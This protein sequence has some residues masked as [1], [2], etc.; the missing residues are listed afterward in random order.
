MQP[1]PVS[2]LLLDCFVALPWHHPGPTCCLFILEMAFPHESPKVLWPE[3]LLFPLIFSKFMTP[4]FTHKRQSYFCNAQSSIRQNLNAPTVVAWWSLACQSA[5]E[6]ASVNIAGFPHG[7]G[8]TEM[9]R[10]GTQNRPITQRSGLTIGPVK[11]RFTH[12]QKPHL[13]FWRVGPLLAY[14]DAGREPGPL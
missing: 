5:T 14:T 12:R 1:G 8:C 3:L 4:L 11:D 10:H 7:R 13:G 6:P 9:G 2:L